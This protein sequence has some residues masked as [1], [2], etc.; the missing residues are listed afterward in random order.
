MNNFCY[1]YLFLMRYL[2]HVLHLARQNIIALISFENRWEVSVKA[3]KAANNERQSLTC[4][5]NSGKMRS[6]FT[7]NYSL[8]WTHASF[9][10]FKPCVWLKS[11]LMITIVLNFYAVGEKIKNVSVPTSTMTRVQ[12]GQAMKRIRFRGL[13]ES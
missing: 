12:N 13:P 1:V 7:N 4:V 11:S 2:F 3:V 9:Q 10:S 8:A 5:N 6:L